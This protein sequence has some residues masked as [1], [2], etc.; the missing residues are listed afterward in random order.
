M[1]LFWLDSHRETAAYKYEKIRSRL[2][3]VFYGRGCHEAE[4]LADETINRVTV[5]M[6]RLKDSYVGETSYYFYAVANNIHLE[7]IRR[8]KTLGFVELKEVRAFDES[9]EDFEEA[10]ERLEKSL[11]QLPNDQR[12]LIAAYYQKEK[13]AKIEH[14]KELAAKCGLS[15]GALKTRACRIRATL[16]KSMERMS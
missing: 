4:E 15:I 11:K 9:E 13:R 6:S 12:E 16:R 1:L 7:W 8:Q 2:I 3:S 14:H 5:K 10:F